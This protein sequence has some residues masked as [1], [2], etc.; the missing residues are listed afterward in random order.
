[1]KNNGTI[2][3]YVAYAWICKVSNQ[4]VEIL[5]ALLWLYT[6]Y[7]WICWNII[8]ILGFVKLITE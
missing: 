5:L 1:M 2:V 8:G 3:V 4:I 7:A 6:A